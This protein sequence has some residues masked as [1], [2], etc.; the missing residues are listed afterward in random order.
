V[1]SD[2]FCSSF[3]KAAPPSRPAGS[4]SVL[5]SG[6]SGAKPIT[7]AAPAEEAVLAS[8]GPVPL[9]RALSQR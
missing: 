2:R 9:L 8:Q 4:R 1:R 6:E 7:R 3:C 5:F